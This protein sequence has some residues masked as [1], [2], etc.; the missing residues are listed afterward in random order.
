MGMGVA[1]DDHGNVFAT[2]N[3]FVRLYG[4]EACG[5]DNVPSS[6][7]RVTA[8]GWTSVMTLPDGTFPNGLT[9]YAGTFYVADSNGAIWSG[10]TGRTTAPTNP[11][12]TS[13]LL[14]PTDETGIGAAD[15]A[16]HAGSVYVTSYAQG[17]LLRIPLAD[18]GA[19]TKARIVAQDSRL[20]R[21]DGLAFDANGRAWIT[22]NPRVDWAAMEQVGGG[23]IAVVTPAGRVSIAA[24]PAESLDYP[25]EAVFDGQG[26]V[27]VANGSYFYG[28]PSLVAFT[29]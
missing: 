21:A 19:A 13:S 24:T 9:T 27:Y 28:T 2:V 6:V 8:S 1:V 22:V 18:D 11:W 29:G 5:P 3:N 20:D 12:Y 7:Q 4:E 15:V 26:T 10:P 25:T 23:S 16:F 14:D 17:L